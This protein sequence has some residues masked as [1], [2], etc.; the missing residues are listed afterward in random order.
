MKLKEDLKSLDNRLLVKAGEEINKS[1]L[2]RLARS[3]GKIRYAKM[4]QLKR[5]LS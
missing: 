5:I 1:F 2:D 3:A 4:K